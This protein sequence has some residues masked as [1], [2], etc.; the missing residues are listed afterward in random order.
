[1]KNQS[2]RKRLIMALVTLAVVPV[3]IVMSIAL[4]NQMETAKEQ[5]I[6]S[7]ISRVQWGAQYLEEMIDY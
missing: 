1:M 6:A 5:V 2:M 3:I 7:N 4:Y